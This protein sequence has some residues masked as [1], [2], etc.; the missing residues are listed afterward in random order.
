MEGGEV[1]KVEPAIV[2]TAVRGV[3]NVLRELGML[4][5]PPEK[6]RY[7][8]TIKKTQWIRAERGGFLQFHVTPGDLVE[9]GQ[10]LTTNTNLLGREQTVLTAPFDSVVMGMTTLPAVS[11]GEPVC[12]L[13]KLPRGARVSELLRLRSAEDGLEER[14]VDELAS[15]LLV[16]DR[17]EENPV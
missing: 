12:H 1:W 10:A 11:P 6:A 8:L 9:K 5:G 3:K 13:G 15:S 4:A 7:K 2:E 17:P 14:V 16:V